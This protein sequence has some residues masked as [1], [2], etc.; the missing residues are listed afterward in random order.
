LCPPFPFPRLFLS[1]FLISPR[2]D[3]SAECTPYYYK[4]VGDAI[5][6]GQF[7]PIWTGVLRLLANDTEAHAK[8]DAINKSVPA[9][10]P[11]VRRSFRFTLGSLGMNQLTRTA[12]GT[13]TGDFS[14]F[15]PS[16]P[17]SDPDCWWTYHQCVNPKLSGLSAD[18][19]SVPEVNRSSMS[20]P[21]HSSR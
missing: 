21:M 3:P 16:Y 12:Q 17:P 15:T 20:I 18:V 11:K 14:N 4:P 1:S 10:G 8:F 2:L 19:A 6:A 9:I 13:L 5:A 7:P